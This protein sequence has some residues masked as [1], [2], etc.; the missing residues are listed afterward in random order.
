[1]S[2]SKEISQY[3]VEGQVS[4]YDKALVVFKVELKSKMHP[5]SY[6]ISVAKR[7]FNVLFDPVLIRKP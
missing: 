1:M 6:R 2:Y 5:T 7:T 4:R 3:S